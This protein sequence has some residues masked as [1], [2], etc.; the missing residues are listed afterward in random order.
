MR[1][2]WQWLASICINCGEMWSISSEIR[3]Q[4]RSQHLAISLWRSPF[5][6][7]VIEQKLLFLI[8]VWILANIHPWYRIQ[9]KYIIQWIWNR[10]LTFAD[11]KVV[12]VSGRGHVNKYLHKHCLGRYHRLIEQYSDVVVGQFYGHQNTDTFRLFYN[13]KSKIG[14]LNNSLSLLDCLFT[15]RCLEVRI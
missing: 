5:Y 12:T 14:I 15:S 8:V 3:T 10:T 2:Q 4:L 7:L 1:R 11:I 9:Y 6:W 13:N